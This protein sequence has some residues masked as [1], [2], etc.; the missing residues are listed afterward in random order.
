MLKKYSISL[1]IA[2][3]LITPITVFAIVNW[4]EKKWSDLPVFEGENYTIKDFQLTN[5]H[6]TTVSLQQWKGKIVV[7]NFF[8]THCPVICPKMTANL[9]TVKAAFPGEKNLLF[10]S[11]SVDPERDSVQKLKA[12]AERF[13]VTGSWHLLTGEKPLIYQLARKS[14]SVVATEEEGSADDFIH[15]EKLVLID[16]TQR[17]RGYYNGTSAAAAQQL[18]QDIKKLQDEK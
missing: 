2:V 15:S 17:I 10:N 5:Q 7:A 11:F 3:V 12:F 14:F 9:L 13:G 6:G 18:I 8:F 4:M 16:K 1:I